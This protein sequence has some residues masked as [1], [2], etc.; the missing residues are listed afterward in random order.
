MPVHTHVSVCVCV[1]VC[2]CECVSVVQG[3]CP[4]LY[5]AVCA[6]A[7]LA[8]WLLH[9]RGGQDKWQHLHPGHQAVVVSTV[10]PIFI[11]RPHLPRGRP[12]VESPT[13]CEEHYGGLLVLQMRK[14]WWKASSM[15][16]PHPP[17][18]QA[19]KTVR[20]LSCLFNPLTPNRYNC[21]YVLF[22]FLRSSCCKKLQTVCFCL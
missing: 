17:P 5:I 10:T 14:I 6:P 21:T 2:V 9:G 16:T 8:W 7:A 22:L 11:P 19:W 1:C 15:I 4:H 20:F 13:A 3:R 12:W 18:N